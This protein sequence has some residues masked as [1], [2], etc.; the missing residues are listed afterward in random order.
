MEQFPRWYENID[1]EDEQAFCIGQSAS[2]LGR[3]TEV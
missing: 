3:Q 2:I 1:I